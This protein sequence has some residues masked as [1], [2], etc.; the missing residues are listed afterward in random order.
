MMKKKMPEFTLS[1]LLKVSEFSVDKMRFFFLL[2]S[3]P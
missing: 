2:N 3:S 1:F